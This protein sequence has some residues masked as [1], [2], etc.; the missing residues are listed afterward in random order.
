MAQAHDTGYK[1]LFSNPEFVRDLLLGFV[2][3][4]WVGQVDFSSLEMLN[5]HYV[6][7]DMQGRYEDMV[8]RLK[9]GDDD[10][11]YLYL[12]LEF[13]S[14]PDRFMALRLLTYI[15]L[16]W[17]QLEKQGRLTRD[18]RLP[19]VLPLVLYNGF[20]PWRH[21]TRLSDLCHPAPAGLQVFQPSFDYL[22]IDENQYPDSELSGRRNLVAMLMRLE[23]AQTPQIM[24]AIID[25]LRGWLTLDDQTHLR[26]NI[27]RWIIGLVRRRTSNGRIPPLSD[28]LEV[29]TMLAE[30]TETWTERWVQEGM[31]KGLEQGREE[32]LEQGRKYQAT[33]LQRQLGRRFGPLPEWAAQRVEQAGQA[34]IGAW[35]EAI[36]DAPSLEELL[37][38]DKP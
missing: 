5:G 3:Q 4:D 15:G 23:Q 12:L 35:A 2:P 1:L 24:K 26:R 11:V 10:W 6:S 38:Q 18:G 29:S 25:E 22:L 30:R 34:Q 14:T 20:K 36:F 31:T 27:I 28:L 32:G 37:G 9:L 7:E 17:Q 13:Q 21:S 19:P 8:W 33:L 16:F